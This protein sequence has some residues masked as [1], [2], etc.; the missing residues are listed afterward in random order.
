[1]RPFEMSGY[2]VATI[3]FDQRKINGAAKGPDCS[4][5]CA[6]LTWYELDELPVS[7]PALEERTEGIPANMITVSATDATACLRTIW[8][9]SHRIGMGERDAAWTAPTRFFERTR[10]EY[11]M[12]AA[13]RPCDTRNEHLA[14]TERPRAT[15]HATQTAAV[16]SR[17]SSVT[18]SCAAPSNFEYASAQSRTLFR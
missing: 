8:R 10:G 1:M 6:L 11:E 3:G 13:V 14:M 18:A 9:P 7:A 12:K 5:E 2:E 17:R 16:T 4:P 15:R